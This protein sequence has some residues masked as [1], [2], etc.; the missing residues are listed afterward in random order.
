LNERSVKVQVHWWFD[1]NRV[2]RFRIDY[3]VN[4]RKCIEVSSISNLITARVQFR[5]GRQRH[6]SYQNNGET[7]TLESQEMEA[8]LRHLRQFEQLV[9]PMCK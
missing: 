9:N 6:M 1:T 4:G 8:V 5:E 7:I 2:C 3:I